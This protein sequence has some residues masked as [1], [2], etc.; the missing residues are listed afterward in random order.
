M[1]LFSSMNLILLSFCDCPTIYLFYCSI[2]FFCCCY[3]F[4]IRSFFSVFFELLLVTF[5]FLF[6]PFWIVAILATA[7]VATSSSFVY[8]WFSPYLPT[9]EII[10]FT[11]LVQKKAKNLISY[12][13]YNHKNTFQDIKRKSKC[14][15]HVPYIVLYGTNKYKLSSVQKSLLTI[16][17]LIPQ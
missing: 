3:C 13:H 11:F 10:Y 8:Q 14:S 17:V 6:F 16:S 15:Y 12:Q 4:P 2:F 5:P 7:I 1:L 9:A